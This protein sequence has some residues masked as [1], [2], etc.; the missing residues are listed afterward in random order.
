MRSTAYRT[1]GAV[2]V[3]LLLVGFATSQEQ[4]AESVDEVSED[5]DLLEQISIYAFTLDQFRTM[6]PILKELEAKRQ[7]LEAY[8][9]SEEALAPMRAVR[10]ALIKDEAS[11]Q[12]HTGVEVV[13]DQMQELEEAYEEAIRPAMEGIAA[14]LTDEQLAM[15][16]L[17][18]EWAFDEADQILADL[19]NARDLDEATFNAWRDQ[20]ARQV[21]FRAAGDSVE[22]AKKVQDNVSQFLNKARNLKEDEYMDRYDDLFDELQELIASSQPKPLRQV[23]EAQAA[24][25]LEFVMRS[26][27]VLPL[28]E[29]RVKA[30]GGG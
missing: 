1:V 19:D 18:E 25:E 9:R 30:L 10:E 15:L 7:A 12:L 24:E 27:R 13:W 16:S 20:K 3:M 4:P 28:I 2:S 26:E 21:A 5:I 17:E 8:K 29:A 22:K 14:L 23:V 11:D 6:I